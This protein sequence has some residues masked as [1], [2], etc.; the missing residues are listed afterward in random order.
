MAKHKSKSKTQAPA[1]VG[2][3]GLGLMGTSI[4][5]CLLA[6]GHPV[7]GIDKDPAKRRNARKHALALL[8]EMRREKLL[9]KDPARLA[10]SLTVAGDFT[11]IG[12]A[13]LVVECIFEDLAAKREVL[14]QVEEVIAP[15]ALIGS[16]TSALPVTELQ[17]GARHP[18]RILGIHWAEPAHITRFMEIICG[19][20][21]DVRNAEKVIAMAR[22]WN[23]EPTLVRRDIRGFITNRIMY[24]MIREAF[25][26]VENGYTTPADVD[27]SVRNDM[28]WWITLAGPFRYMDLTGIPAYD[29]VMR[30]LVPELCRETQV[31]KLMQKVVDS[32]A[33]GVANAKGFYSYTPAQAK[34][35]EKRFL[36]FNY[37][38]RALAL[39]YR[40]RPE[41]AK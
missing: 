20:Q 4:T 34:R 26:L 14:R 36:A 33:R 38:I 19:A 17:R 27:R 13:A 28:G 6:A 18:E 3:I 35:W 41:D 29:A 31:P 25:Y 32:G 10:A 22:R 5:T 9:S 30:D 11:D 39:K 16:N 7:V 23:K 40:E 15:E 21:T 8:L 37:D 24:A 1:P 12:P 2:V